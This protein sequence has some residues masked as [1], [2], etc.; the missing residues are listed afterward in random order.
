MTATYQTLWQ[1][2]T[3]SGSVQP[4]THILDNEASVEMKEAIKKNC[5]IQLTPLN[6][7]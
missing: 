1:R 7:H 5:K 6:N 3:E 2:L 4:T